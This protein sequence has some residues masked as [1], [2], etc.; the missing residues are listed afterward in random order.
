VASIH[1]YIDFH[2]GSDATDA[3]AGRAMLIFHSLP[4][5]ARRMLTRQ[6]IG[7]MRGR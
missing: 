6:L 4:R 2:F 7:E 3:G 1:Q 5:V